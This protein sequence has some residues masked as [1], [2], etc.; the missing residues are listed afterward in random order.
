MIMNLIY[1]IVSAIL[2]LGLIFYILN[3]ALKS[4]KFKTRGMINLFVG[5]G[6][7][8][9]F[10][11]TLWLD[12]RGDTLLN[13]YYYFI[14]IGVALIYG[15]AYAY[16]LIKFVRRTSRLNKRIISKYYFSDHLYVVYRFENN[17]Y[18]QKK[19]DKYQGL[20]LKLGKSDFHDSLLQSLNKRLQVAVRCDIYKAGKYT[21][22]TRRQAYYC[23]VI[24]LLEQ[25]DLPGL[26]MINAYQLINVNQDDFD[27]EILYRIILGEIFD[28]EK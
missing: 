21:L 4:L 5:L 23:Y 22:L 19:K 15:L 14:F 12:Y 2:I 10:G 9:A 8:A 13:Y 27:K 1:E 11:I 24:N 28:I 6:L 7:S 17:Y 25:Q 18:L 16:Y 20:I 3:E 26:E